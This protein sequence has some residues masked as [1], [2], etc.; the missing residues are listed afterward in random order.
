MASKSEWPVVPVRLDTDKSGPIFFTQ[1][2]WETIEAATSRVFPTDHRPGAREA[3]V[4]HYIDRY[5]SGI[6]Y[7]YASADGSGFLKLSGKLAD[8]WRARVTAM[9]T[10]YR[11]G[12][13]DLDA[14][15][16]KLA[17][18]DFKKLT[19]EQQDRVFV[20]LSGRP[21]PGHIKL[22][23]PGKLGTM[24]QGVSDDEA[25]FF[26]MLCLHS[27]QG[28]FGDPAYGGNRGRVG[29]NL[30]EFPGPKSLKDTNDCS[31]N[32]KEH[33]VQEYDWKDLI[34]HLREATS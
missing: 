16:H 27:R 33:F 10:K 17:K 15:A 14:R 20:E 34:P 24:L 28:M 4:V 30:V 19:E 23:D 22:T 1:H 25:S 6:D 31:Y 2:E 18:R 21:K 11:A 8:A 7:I 13:S 12:I 9:Q 32:V 5:I 3:G 26:E 29:W